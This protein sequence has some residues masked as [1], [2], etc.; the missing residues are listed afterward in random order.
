[1]FEK[2]QRVVKV[3]GKD[4]SL[5]PKPGMFGTFKRSKVPAAQ[6]TATNS[7][8]E[9]A[10]GAANRI[11][12]NIGRPKRG[13]ILDNKIAKLEGKHRE[14]EDLLVEQNI[15]GTLR[16]FI[17]R[18]LISAIV[19]SIMV[20]LATILLFIKIGQPLLIS[21]VIGV[22]IIYLVYRMTLMTFI[23]YPMSRNKK[24]EKRVERDILF[25]VRDMIISLRSGMPLYN[26]IASVST[27]YG[28]A[29]R[30]FRKIIER[31]QLGMPLEDA[32]D[33]SISESKSSSFRKVMIQASVSVRAG[34]DVVSSI[35]TIADE[36]AQERI[37]ELRRYGQKLNAIAMFYMLFGVILPSMGLAVA[38]IL[39]TFI[40]IFQITPQILYGSLIGIFFLQI[41]FM[42]L[43]VSSRPAFSM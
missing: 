19:V 38:T 29:S 32:L 31:A 43:I 17:R 1:M 27:G 18:M 25:A 22:G 35:Q 6:N 36:L 34:A 21:L 20:G 3:D 7:K 8:V 33:K 30:E 39:T 26:A 11:T 2:K 28:D 42:K 10:T 4:V 24:G 15:R 9:A 13:G 14:L 12:S 16:G 5:E 23:N 41:V 40:S 37:I